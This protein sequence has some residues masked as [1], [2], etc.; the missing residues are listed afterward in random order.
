MVDIHET[1]SAITLS[2][3]IVCFSTTKV[4]KKLQVFLNLIY[5]PITICYIWHWMCSWNPFYNCAL[6][7]E[8]D[9]DQNQLVFP[10]SL[11][12]HRNRSTH[13]NCACVLQ[14]FVF[15]EYECVEESVLAYSTSVRR[16][17]SLMPVMRGRNTVNGDTWGLHSFSLV[18]CGWGW[19]SSSTAIWI[20]VLC[21]YVAHCCNWMWARPRVNTK[22]FV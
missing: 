18:T 7:Q 15:C 17:R 12:A 16:C 2:D 20:P 5:Y 13:T 21:T 19:S 22:E 9:S 11:K 4:V 3:S 14:M 1:A 6:N 8:A 10:T